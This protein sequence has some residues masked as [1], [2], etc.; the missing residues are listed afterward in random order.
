MV[1]KFINPVKSG[2][3]PASALPS[4]HLQ[5]QDNSMLIIGGTST[6][7]TISKEKTFTTTQQNKNGVYKLTALLS[8][9]A[10]SNLW[11]YSLS[12]SSQIN[13]CQAPGLQNF[14]LDQ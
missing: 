10:L 5:S 14:Q 4:S 12:N 9:S 1:F 2:I 7:S 6:D 13:D 3:G 11:E 8:H